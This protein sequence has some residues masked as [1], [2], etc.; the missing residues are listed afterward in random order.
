MP[1]SHISVVICAYSRERWDKLVDAVVSIQQ[2]TML[3]QEI[4]LVI[5]HNEELFQSAQSR[6][7]EIIV[8]ENKEPRGLSGARNSGIAVADGEFIAFLDDDAV[9]EPDWLRSMTV[10]LEDP[11]VLGAGGAVLP[12]WEQQK[13]PW[14]PAEFQWV[15][16]CSYIGMPHTIAPVRN[17]IGANMCIRKEVFLTVG[18]FRNGIGRVGTLPI[19]CEETELCIRAHQH[20]P[21]RHFLYLPQAAVSHYVP[22]KRATWRYF[23]TRCYAE[24]ISKAVISRFVGA[25][26]SLASESTYTMQTLPAGIVRALGD[27]VRKQQIAGFARAIAII[28]GLVV[29]TA[30]YL[31]GKY[32]SLSPVE[33][34]E[35]SVA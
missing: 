16:G 31:V 12:A 23:Y 28:S 20:W 17:P 34:K 9:A 13:P 25:K 22:Q 19:G 5:D 24:G 18:C 4:I 35:E 6:F 30:G 2:Q 8:I 1:D 32:A 15:V 29:T 33:N 26:D 7:P 21:E 27:V 11:C 14:F 10:V 3:A